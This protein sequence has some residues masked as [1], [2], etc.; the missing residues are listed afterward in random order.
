MNHTKI[1][2]KQI[3]NL[4]I[5]LREKIGEKFHDIGFGNDFLDTRPKAQAKK[6]KIDKTGPQQILKLYQ[7]TKQSKRKSLKRFAN[8][9]CDK[10]SISRIYKVFLQLN[11]KLTIQLENG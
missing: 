10:G 7:R 9:T 4:N 6:L 8:H 3:K 11:K 5:K 1:N 2:S